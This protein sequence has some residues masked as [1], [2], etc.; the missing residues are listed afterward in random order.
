MTKT[1]LR[2]GLYGA[3]VE[4]LFFFVSLI[5]S[6]VTKANYE[7]LKIN[8]YP[9]IIVCISLT[10]FGIRY[11][12]DKINGGSITFYDALKLG[13]LIVLIPA[14]C[15]G[16][17]DAL[18]DTLLD[19]HFYDRLES[20]KIKQIHQN[21]SATE[22]PVRLKT[23][24]AQLDFYRKPYVNFLVMF[25]TVTA[26]GIVVSVISAFILQRKSNKSMVA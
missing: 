6:G 22:L 16:F 11:Y 19:P 9:A 10:Y 13:I 15:F 1:I 14:V 12:R 3:L 26:P 24:K 21:I 20:D 17:S 23:F 7:V 2:F 25:L 5:I 18:Y 8:C 4:V